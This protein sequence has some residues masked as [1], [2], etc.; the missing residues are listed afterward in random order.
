MQK[1]LT[2]SIIWCK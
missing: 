2:E 1:Y